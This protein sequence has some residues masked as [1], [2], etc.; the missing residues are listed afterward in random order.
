MWVV[1][2]SK[3][4]EK[5]R[6]PAAIRNQAMDSLRTRYGPADALISAGDLMTPD[7]G[8]ERGSSFTALN[9]HSGTGERKTRRGE[10]LL[11]P[12]QEHSTRTMA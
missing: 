11:S 5:M 12:P 2:P 3:R 4:G 8:E 10:Q 7:A 6:R 1:P 9:F